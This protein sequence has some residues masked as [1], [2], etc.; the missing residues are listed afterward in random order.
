M[1]ALHKSNPKTCMYT[2]PISPANPYTSIAEAGPFLGASL[3]SCG[4]RGQAEPVAPAT[5]L[6]EDRIV[7]S[8]QH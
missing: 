1:Y 2:K 6:G 4:W 7:E 8:A 5:L 3:G